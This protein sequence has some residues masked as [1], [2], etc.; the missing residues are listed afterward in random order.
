MKNKFA[1]IMFLLSLP[2]GLLTSCGGDSLKAHENIVF[3]YKNSENLKEATTNKI[4]DDKDTKYDYN[5][6]I[7]NPLDRE[8]RE[9]FAFGVDA[10]MIH[11][12]E[13]CGAKFYNKDGYE[14]DVFTLLKEGGANYFRVRLWNDPTYLGITYGG[15]ANDLETDIA[16]AKRA[17]DVGMNILVDFHY[18]DFW[19]DPDYQIAP[20]AW[21]SM[22]AKNIPNAVYEFTKSSI[23]SFKEAGITVN[24][25]QIGNEINN[26]LIGDFGAINWADPD[27]S[28]K[29]VSE[30]LTS[31]IKG[32]R[33]VNDDI[34]TII[35][36]A[37]GGSWDEFEAYFTQ[38]EKNGVP[39]DIIGASYYPFYHGSIDLLAKN[40]NNCVKTFNKPV[41]VMETSYGNTTDSSNEWVG[42]TYNSSCEDS[43]GYITGVQGQTTSLRDIVN[44]VNNVENRMGLG[45]F[46][47]EP[48]WLPLAPK[49]LDNYNITEHSAGWATEYG[50]CYKNFNNNFNLLDQIKANSG[51]NID[52][53]TWANQGWF[54]YNGKALPS[55]YGYKIIKE[56]GMNEIE[57]TPLKFREKGMAYTLNRADSTDKGP[58][59][60]KCETNL[61]AIRDYDVYWGSEGSLDSYIAKGD[62][63]YIITGYLKD[64]PNISDSISLTLTIIQN[65]VIDGGFEIQ[66]TSDDLVAPWEIISKS[67]SNAKVVKL[68]RKPTD[69]RTGTTDLNWYYGVSRS[70]FKIGQ[71]IELEEAATYKLTTYIMGSETSQ[72]EVDELN[73]FAEYDGESIKENALGCLVGW[74]NGYK[75]VSLEFTT[76]KATT[77]VIGVEANNI[78][79]QGWGHIDD[80][81]LVKEA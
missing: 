66:G 34:I 22:K 35:H 80:F 47:W 28:F 52:K 14:Q 45:V 54:D 21:K 55:L 12:L 56:G 15:G 70:S 64:Y 51:N 60:A 63:T 31:G 4:S 8:L 27:S 39:Y 6:L 58:T 42:N 26:G 71:T 1:K 68:N 2:L 76:T 77:V 32:A 73:L 13:E 20:K 37:N 62:G 19:A 72:F 69:V 57:E 38:L 9:D 3:T 67:P 53:S 29:T 75:P 40:L 78:Q 59:T 18:S 36:L 30:I 44:T 10:S 79:S 61:D 41:M 17:Q 11:E 5:S 65:Y 7:V 43:G 50:L 16:L 23:E 46:Y 33:E 48:T 81:E 25:V 24:A 49:K 74:S